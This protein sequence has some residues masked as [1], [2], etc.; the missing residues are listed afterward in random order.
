M[1]ERWRAGD[2]SWCHEPRKVI[3]PFPSLSEV[4]FSEIVQAPPLA[5]NIERHY[6]RR[7]GE[8]ENL[9]IDRA[10]G[11]EHPWQ[12]RLDGHLGSYRRVGMS[13]LNPRPW[14]RAEMAM[15]K[16]TL[17]AATDMVTIFYVVSSSS[18]L[19]HLGREGLDE[20]LAA[21][22]QICLQLFWERQ[23]AIDI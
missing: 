6:D 4:I 8:I 20:C 21:I 18:M 22:D 11:F 2:W 9:W 3:P 15:A 16:A 12:R 14:F 10:F 13:Y 23:G 17:D 19:S 1:H 7:T 5:A